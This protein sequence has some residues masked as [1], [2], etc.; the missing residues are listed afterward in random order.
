MTFPLRVWVFHRTEK[1]RKNC[2][3]KNNKGKK[4][5]KNEGWTQGDN[6][7]AR[8]Q[9]DFREHEYNFNSPL[10]WTLRGKPGVHHAC[11]WACPPSDK[12]RWFPPVED[13]YPRLT[14]IYRTFQKSHLPRMKETDLQPIKG[15]AFP[16][17]SAGQ[18]LSRECSRP[19]IPQTPLEMPSPLPSPGLLWPDGNSA[20]NC[21][22]ITQGI[23]V[24]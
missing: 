6:Y 18:R 7:A 10:L 2:K 21:V 14:T 17:A 4:W 13:P 8:K 22:E 24:E 9:P 15:A 12:H 19:Q 5:H 1:E 23:K 11:K 3:L 20:W 16:K